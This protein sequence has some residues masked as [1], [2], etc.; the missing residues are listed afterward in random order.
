MVKGRNILVSGATGLIGKHVVRLLAARGDSTVVA[1]VRDPARLDVPASVHVRAFDFTDEKAAEELMASESWYAHICCLGTTLS[2]A[3]SREA[4]LTI[5]RD[6]PLRLARAQAQRCPQALFAY[7]S[8]AG[9]GAPMG[10][11]LETKAETEGAL[12][13]M[14]LPCL[15]VRPSLL[16]GE[17]QESRPMERLAVG[18]LGPLSSALDR[19]F[20]RGAQW[21]GRVLPIDATAVSAALVRLVMNAKGEGR[22]ES[23]EGW[24]LR[25]AASNLGI[26]T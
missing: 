9:A 22:P 25:F 1:L 6:I 24:P 18:F 19:P 11:Y 10:F 8:S 4:F 12:R 14:G 23:I 5:D 16:L 17:R 2:A 20:F 15:I 7:V 26:G 21:L 13:A 3:G